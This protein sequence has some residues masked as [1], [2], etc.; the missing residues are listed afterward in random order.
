MSA[1]ISR[2]WSERI[3]LINDYPNDGPDT[4]PMLVI[5]DTP[6]GAFPTL[7][8]IAPYHDYPEN[9]AGNQLREA[10]REAVVI[11]EYNGKPDE[12]R[13]ELREPDGY[14]VR[15][16]DIK[17]EIAAL[18][19]LGTYLDSEI[20]VVRG[21]H[22]VLGII[23]LDNPTTIDIPYMG[24]PET[25]TGE[26]LHVD[27]ARAQDIFLAGG[28][29]ALLSAIARLEHPMP[30]TESATGVTDASLFMPGAPDLGDALPAARDR[31]PLPDTTEPLGPFIGR[32]PV[33]TP[34]NAF[35]EA[36]TADLGGALPYDASR[37]QSVE[38]DIMP[39]P[40]YPWMPP[41]EASSDYNPGYPH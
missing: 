41:G 15:F 1:E 39:D 40:T 37:P 4:S 16:T 10:V 33:P 27:T 14:K 23:G 9:P 5:K 35:A 11:P 7:A 12:H 21:P 20:T 17:P 38:I 28:R 24:I 18:E 2:A 6:E 25:H 8:L 3:P 29:A 30:L 31:Y 22:D 19:R 34:W 36:P 32:Y 13:I 26:P